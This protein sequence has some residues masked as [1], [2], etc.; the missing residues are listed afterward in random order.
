MT[1][2]RTEKT[3]ND[4][5]KLLSKGLNY[6]F[7]FNSPAIIEYNYWR[8]IK[9]KFPYDAVAS[10]HCLLTPNRIFQYDFEM[11]AEEQAELYDIKRYLEKR[12]DSI[13]ENFIHKRTFPKHY[14]LHVIKFKE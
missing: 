1:I 6:D 14:H 2:L 11:S 9:N 4:Y 3:L 5:Q 13:F 10:E 12:F 8:L 7:F